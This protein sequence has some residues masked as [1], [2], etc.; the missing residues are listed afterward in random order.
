MWC[1][2]RSV[3]T[4]LDCDFNPYLLTNI[5]HFHNNKVVADTV[6]SE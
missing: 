6:A 2:I 1:K 5:H 3:T 4:W